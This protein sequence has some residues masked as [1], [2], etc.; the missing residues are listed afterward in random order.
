MRVDH[1]VPYRKCLDSLIFCSYTRLSG[2][3]Q[4]QL[5]L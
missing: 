1:R 2:D 5:G 4:I 3:V